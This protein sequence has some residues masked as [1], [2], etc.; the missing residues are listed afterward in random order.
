MASALESDSEDDEL[1]Q[2]SFAT[3]TFT[4]TAEMVDNVLAVCPGAGREVIRT[5]LYYTNSITTTINRILD[6]RVEV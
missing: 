4:V 2:P 3:K 1:L 5:D 6:G